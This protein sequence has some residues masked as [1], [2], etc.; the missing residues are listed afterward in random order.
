[1]GEAGRL[2]HLTGRTAFRR[3]VEGVRVD[4]ARA[5]DDDDRTDH[6]R[7]QQARRGGAAVLRARP[8]RPRRTPALGPA[9][10]IDARARARAVSAMGRVAG[11]GRQ[12]QRVRRVR[13]AIH[14]ARR[15]PVTT[16]W[17]ALHWL[18]SR[19]KGFASRPDVRPWL[20]VGARAGALA[21]LAAFAFG[22]LMLATM[23]AWWI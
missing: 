2:A 15:R 5:A 17:E 4:D 6:G 21:I 7:R 19:L 14:A 9:Q 11:D 20:R 10:R 18:A 1:M 3:A 13:I 22:V 23:V 8:R 16:M 12:L